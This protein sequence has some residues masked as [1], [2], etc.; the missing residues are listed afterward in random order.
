MTKAIVVLQSQDAAALGAW[1]AACL[2]SVRQWSDRRGFAYRFEGDECFDR[3]PSELRS[4]FQSNVLLLSDLA[5]LLWLQEVLDDGFEY[6]IWCDADLLIF[7]NFLPTEVRESFGRECWIQLQG[8]RLRAYKKIHNAWLLF[9]RSSP[10]LSFY[11]D[12]ALCLLER[13]TPPLVP[14]FLGPKLLTAWHNI[15]PFNVEEQVG[16]LS[17]LSAKDLL[18]GGHESLELMR[19]GHAT[20]IK[21]LNLSGSYESRPIDGVCHGPEEYEALVE[22]LMVHGCTSRF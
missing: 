4:K 17:P 8:N 14:Q 20:T 15:A 22:H 10:V 5:R 16:M 21:A 12:R 2:D 9:H 11:L 1:Q 18:N 13:A 6:A 3:I 7:D 19:E